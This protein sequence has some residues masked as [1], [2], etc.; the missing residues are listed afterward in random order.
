MRTRSTVVIAG[1]LFLSGVAVLC[2][3]GVARRQQPL[4]LTEGD[5]FAPGSAIADEVV[6]LSDRDGVTDLYRSD[7]AGT[8]HRLTVTSEEESWPAL[9]PDGTQLAYA[10][11]GQRYWSIHL[12]DLVTGRSKV[13]VRTRYEPSALSLS[14]DHAMVAYVEQRSNDRTAVMVADTRATDISQVA[15]GADQP[16]WLYHDEAIGYREGD[17]LVFRPRSMDTVS[18]GQSVTRTGLIG[19]T[20]APGAARDIIGLSDRDGTVRWFRITISSTDETSLETFPLSL[21]RALVARPADGDSVTVLDRTSQTDTPNPLWLVDLSSGDVRQL[22]DRA[23]AVQWAPDGSIVAYAQ[24]TADQSH[25]V[26]HRPTAA[27]DDIVISAS[28]LT[29]AP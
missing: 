1:L 21:E 4:P 3:V 29:V 2:A 18:F 7:A 26:L 8:I 12:L 19:A 24:P 28:W 16:F 11:R 25:V 22:T 20:A 5:V 14:S 13:V 6:F 10:V 9:S 23:R 17:A 15:L 27:Q